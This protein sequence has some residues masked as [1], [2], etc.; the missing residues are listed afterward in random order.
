[1][2]TNRSIKIRISNRGVELSSKRFFNDEIQI[3]RDPKCDIFLDNP[4]V[5]RRHARIERNDEGF[6]IFDQES[7]NGTFL[8]EKKINRARLI[9]GDVIR[10]SKFT[11]AIELAPVHAATESISDPAAEE[12]PAVPEIVEANDGETVFLLPGQQLKILE[13]AKEAERVSEQIRTGSETSENS[14]RGSVALIFIVGAA[15]GILFTWL[16]AS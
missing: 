1:M 7:G 11:L 14:K 2:T 5:S 10:I 4:G 8:N 3:G 15:F 16:L 9:N 13:Q 6:H 12:S